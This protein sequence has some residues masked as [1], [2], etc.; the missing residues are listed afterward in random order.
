MLLKIAVMGD[1]HGNLP[2]LEA[3]L[4][5]AERGKPDLMISVGD[6]VNLGPNPRE[7][8]RLLK[9]HHVL[10]LRGNHERYL[11]RAMQG[12]PAYAAVNFASLRF[13]A[14]MLT[15]QELSLPL[16]YEQ[17]PLLFTHALP[18]DDR[19][20]VHLPDTALPLLEKQTGAP[21]HIICGHGHDPRSYVVGDRTV[22]V[23]GSVGCMDHGL[24]GIAPYAELLLEENTFCC[25]QKLA[26]YDP[27]RL[28]PLFVQSGYAEACPIM[29]RVICTQM[30]LN[31]GFLLEF[32]SMAE[33]TAR[34][35]GERQIS[36]AVWQETERRFPWPDGKTL[37]EFWNR[38]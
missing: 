8:L 28:Y 1:I 22:H 14:E 5:D 20:P 27:A 36:A 31:R 24:P 30:E 12:D 7:V 34:T 38:Q 18:E 17:G 35:R 10:C 23:V 21:K 13:F 6:Q 3:V 37:A 9:E 15:E 19:F 25:S 29:A 2:A 11:L 33:Q 26:A 32:V 16:T 4:E